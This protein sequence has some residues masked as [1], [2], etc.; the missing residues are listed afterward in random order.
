M[1][2]SDPRLQEALDYWHGKLSGRAMPA[3]ADLDPAEIPRLLPH[4]M[5]VEVLGP[6]RY[7]YRLIGTENAQAHGMNATGRLL[8]EVL[9]GNEYKGHVLGLYDACVAERR[10]LY[11]ESL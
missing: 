11:S 4:V 5:L 9:P 7:R 8:D 1:A 2:I 6:G 3:R 10:P